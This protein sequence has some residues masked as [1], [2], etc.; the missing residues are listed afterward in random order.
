VAD[1]TDISVSGVTIDAA[2]PE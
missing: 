2:E 1:I